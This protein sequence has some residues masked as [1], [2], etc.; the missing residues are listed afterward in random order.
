MFSIFKNNYTKLVFFVISLFL[1]LSNIINVY[2]INSDYVVEMTF[3]I[4]G[5]SEG[6]FNYPVGIDLDQ[7]DNIYV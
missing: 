4:F 7:N 5:N 3:G 2:A 1:M 6:E